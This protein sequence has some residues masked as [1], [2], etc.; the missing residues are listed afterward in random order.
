[1][2]RV[3]DAHAD[4]RRQGRVEAAEW[5]EQDGGEAAVHHNAHRHDAQVRL[6]VARLA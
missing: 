6:P 2:L 4:P 5:T 1:M 3:G